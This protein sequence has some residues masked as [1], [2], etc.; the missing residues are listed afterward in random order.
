MKEPK[1]Q[2]QIA[3]ELKATLPK[4]QAEAPKVPEDKAKP[5]TQKPG[6]DAPSDKSP[7]EVPGDQAPEKTEQPETDKAKDAAEAPKPEAKDDKDHRSPGAEKRINELVGQLKAEKAER[8]QDKEKMRAIEAELVEL[9]SKVEKP[10][11]EVDKAKKV[12]EAEKKRIAQYLTED[13][14]LPREERRELSDDEIEEWIIE[15]PVKAQEWIAD[16][17]ARRREERNADLQNL[18]VEREADTVIKQREVSQ[19]RVFQKHPEL[20]FEAR[21]KELA[22]TGLNREAV[23]KQIAKENPKM[24]VILEI[25][26][27]P[28]AQDKYAFSADGPEKLMQEMESRLA[29][30]TPAKKQEESS[31]EREAKIAAEAAEAERQRQSQVDAAARSTR[32]S[33][34]A[35]ESSPEYKKQL[36]IFKSLGKTD[37]E[38]KAALDRQLSRR[39]SMNL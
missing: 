29:K 33:S 34:G 9:R 1:S 31:E 38:A 14:E 35:D 25:I 12:S 37:A 6:S 36:A 3:A 2:E 19:Q 24:G 26:Q 15:S 17:A 16:R 23:M 21:A 4:K 7:A 13:K 5:D 28:G 8:L 18:E 30:K 11:Q 27:E 32:G 10:K 39:A 22:A 20:A